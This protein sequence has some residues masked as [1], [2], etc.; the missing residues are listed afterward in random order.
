[1]SPRT[2]WRRHSPAYSAD[3]RQP[4]LPLRVSQLATPPTPG[5]R[6][7]SNYSSKTSC[8]FC[9]FLAG[10]GDPRPKAGWAGTQSP[11]ANS[12]PDSGPVLWAPANRHPLPNFPPPALRPDRLFHPKRGLNLGHDFHSPSDPK[13]WSRLRRI[14]HNFLSLEQARVLPHSGLGFHPRLQSR[15]AQTPPTGRPLELPT[16][17]LELGPIRS[18]RRSRTE[19]TPPKVL[20]RAPT[21]PWPARTPLDSPGAE[22]PP[23]RPPAPLANFPPAQGSRR[24]SA[25]R[26]RFDVAHERIRATFL[27]G[28]PEGL[29]RPAP[30]FLAAKQLSRPKP[31][32]RCRHAFDPGHNSPAIGPLQAHLPEGFDP[33][34]PGRAVRRS[35][36]RSIRRSIHPRCSRSRQARHPPGFGFCPTATGCRPTSRGDDC[37]GG[38]TLPAEGPDH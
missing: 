33:A 8:Q 24:P 19:A 2:P 34:L 16:P 18:T 4:P 13:S 10:S 12:G 30:G 5:R 26:R 38:G 15:S 25:D 22:A 29:R 32:Q 3:P 7:T 23:G 28:K 31:A 27:A 35:A 17:P 6:P 14:R 11:P 9:D 20:P 1:M 37:G 21:V 36:A